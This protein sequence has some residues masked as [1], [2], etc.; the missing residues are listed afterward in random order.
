[1]GQRL[2]RPDNSDGRSAG[3]AEP[4]KKEMPNY[5]TSGALAAEQNTYRGVLLKYSEPPEARKPVQHYRFYIFKGKEQ[6]DM[7][8]VFRQSAY[9]FGRERLVADI[10]ID[11]PSCSKQHAVLQY[12]HA[13]D[14]DDRSRRIVKPYIIDL[15]SS[16]GTFL[17]GER[18]EGSRYYELH[19]GDTI[20]FGF[21]SRDYVLMT[22]ESAD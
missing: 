9:L 22:E 3:G 12:R 13:P 10:P 19:V 21:S 7:L 18:I 14:P 8:Q 20:K 15:E 1:G 6:T 5:G 2:S 16:N 11:H 4:V 17:N